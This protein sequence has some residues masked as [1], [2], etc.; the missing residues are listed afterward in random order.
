MKLRDWEL[1]Q[2]VDNWVGIGIEEDW[3]KKKRNFE[4]KAV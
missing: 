3:R 4:L 1:N 2:R